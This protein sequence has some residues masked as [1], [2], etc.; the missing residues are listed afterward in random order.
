MLS[1]G[2][3]VDIL[4]SLETVFFM[5]LLRFHTMVNLMGRPAVL[6]CAYRT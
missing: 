6:L 4:A 3:K 2:R 5:F 1:V